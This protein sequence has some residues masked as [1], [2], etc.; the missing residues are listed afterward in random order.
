MAAKKYTPIRLSEDWHKYAEVQ[1]LGMTELVETALAFYKEKNEPF[2]EAHKAIYNAVSDAV[3]KLEA[4]REY[5]S[6]L[7][8]EESTAYELYNKIWDDLRAHP[9]FI[10]PN[11]D[12]PE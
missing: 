5:E 6:P 12:L 7:N 8:A 2:I 11:I 10:E 9:F 3:Q 4:K 1:G